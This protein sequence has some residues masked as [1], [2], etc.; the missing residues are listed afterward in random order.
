MWGTFDLEEVWSYSE[1]LWRH[2][3]GITLRHGPIIRQH[4]VPNGRPRYWEYTAMDLMI[5][6]LSETILAFSRPTAAAAEA[7]K[8]QLD[9]RGLKIGHVLQMSRVP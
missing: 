5:G 4:F 2:R 7:L 8:E 1:A 6:P 3:S 9:N